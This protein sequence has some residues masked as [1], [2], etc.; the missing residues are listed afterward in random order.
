MRRGEREREGGGE[1]RTAFKNTNAEGHRTIR[2][3]VEWHGNFAIDVEDAATKNAAR[4]SGHVAVEVGL[5][6]VRQDDLVTHPVL[7]VGAA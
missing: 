2:L 7:L 6:R 3:V 5:V 1:S 4:H